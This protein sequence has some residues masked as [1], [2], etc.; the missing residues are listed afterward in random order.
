M[1]ELVNPI[2]L[3]ATSSDLMSRLK[4]KKHPTLPDLI[5]P[6]FL[7]LWD[8]NPDFRELF[9]A[10]TDDYSKN[11]STK[12][13]DTLAAKMVQDEARAAGN[14]A[15]IEYMLSQLR[16]AVKRVATRFE[17]GRKDLQEELLKIEQSAPTTE[18]EIKEESE[19]E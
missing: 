2:Q 9:E 8:E 18:F 11:G 10:P 14:T 15:V 7:K 12:I 5:M 4:L 3:P 13:D 17:M 16:P 6:I 19:T 1:N